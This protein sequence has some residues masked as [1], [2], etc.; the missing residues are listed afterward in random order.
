MG[1]FFKIDLKFLP[2]CF[3]IYDNTRSKDIFD[4]DLGNIPILERMSKFVNFEFSKEVIIK[5]IVFENEI[6]KLLDKI[7]SY[8]EDHQTN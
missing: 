4:T 5:K 2:S 8:T 1:E 7:F 3:N 6:T